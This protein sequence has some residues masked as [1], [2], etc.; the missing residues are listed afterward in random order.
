MWYWTQGCMALGVDP[1][2]VINT[3]KEKLMVRLS[4]SEFEVVMKTEKKV[5]YR[6]TNN[7]RVLLLVNEREY[8]NKE[9]QEDV[10]DFVGMEVERT[11]YGMKTT[12]LLEFQDIQLVAQSFE[13]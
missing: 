9:I 13:T 6:L 11:R 3:N 12:L 4:Q 2:D 8:D 5:T 1:N 7:P 10:S